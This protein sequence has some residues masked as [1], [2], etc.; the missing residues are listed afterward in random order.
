M[1][2]TASFC[3]VLFII[4]GSIISTAQEGAKKFTMKFEKDKTVSYHTASLIDMN[5]TMNIMGTDQEIEMKIDLFYD[6]DLTPV[7][8]QEN[9][10]TLLLLEPKNILAYWKMNQAGMP[11]E[12]VLEDE[13]IIAESNG[14]VFIDTKNGI[15]ESEAESIMVEMKGLYETGKIEITPEGSI[16]T[17]EG[18]EDFET[19]WKENIESTIGFFGIVFSEEKVKTDESWKVPFSLTNM[20]EIQLAEALEFEV[21]FA[22]KGNKMVEGN[23]YQLFKGS[24]PY[25]ATGVKGTMG[26]AAGQMQ[27]DI[28]EF[29][30]SADFDIVFDSKRGLVIDNK[31][32]IDGKAKMSTAIEGSEMTM[33]L[34]MKAEMDIKLIEN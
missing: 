15:G 22:W 26:D 12:M 24:S 7:D 10:N 18:S 6:M 29:Q 25:D 20:G 21:D 28:N 23:E 9:G 34:I 13:E 33:D 5:M 16:G 27:L 1:K 31:T 30:R 32:V 17:I 8:F 14:T 4:L 3:L 11:V 2:K 19:F